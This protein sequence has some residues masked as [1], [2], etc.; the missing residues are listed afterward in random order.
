M[1][2][3]VTAV[4]KV[5]VT[6]FRGAVLLKVTFQTY[7]VAA[8]MTG[9]AT[10]TVKVVLIAISDGRSSAKMTMSI[11]LLLILVYKSI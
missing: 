5:K 4:G 11:G 2:W 3:T 9:L 6:V 1:L 8:L 7:C 10:A